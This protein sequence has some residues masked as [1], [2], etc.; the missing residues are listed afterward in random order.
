MAD[1]RPKI[2]FYKLP[3]YPHDNEIVVTNTVQSA[4]QLDANRVF[5]LDFSRPLRKR[6]RLGFVV[7]LFVPVIHQTEEAGGFAIGCHTHDPDF[8]DVQTLWKKFYPSTKSH[9]LAEVGDLQIIADFATHFP[10]FCQPAFC[11]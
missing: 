9:R 7:A 4:E 1:S 11:R 2:I 10:T 6:R 3:T 8:K 5:L